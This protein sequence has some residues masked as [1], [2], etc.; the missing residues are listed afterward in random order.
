[1][2]RI[3][4]PK[5]SR[6]EKTPKVC[7][8]CG[9][10][11]CQTFIHSQ[12]GRKVKP[13]THQGRI[14]FAL[15]NEF[16]AII[17]DLNRANKIWGETI[18]GGVK[19]PPLA[20]IIYNAE[21][22]A[23]E[24]LEASRR[25]GD[26]LE[27]AD[28]IPNFTLPPDLSQQDHYRG[29]TVPLSRLGLR[30]PSPRDISNLPLPL[31]NEGIGKIDSLMRATKIGPFHYG[32]S[33]ATF[34][35]Q[36]M[37]IQP[38]ARHELKLTV[39]KTLQPLQ[40]RMVTYYDYYLGFIAIPNLDPEQEA[41]GAIRIAWAGVELMAALAC[42][43]P[44][45]LNI[46]PSSALK[47]YQE[48]T[49]FSDQTLSG[50]NFQKVMGMETELSFRKDAL[51]PHLQRY[52][53]LDKEIDSRAAEALSHQYRSQDRSWG[54]ENE[55][56]SGGALRR[57]ARYR[58]DLRSEVLKSPDKYLRLSVDPE[59]VIRDV[60]IA[61][62]NKQTL[63]LIVEIADGSHVTLEA[64]NNSRLFGIP[65]QLR[66]EFP[67][68]DDIIIKDVITP[69]LDWARPR[70]PRVEP[71]TKPATLTLSRLPD[72]E[73]YKESLRV[74]PEQVVIK[75]PKRRTLR[76]AIQ[77]VTREPGLPQPPEERRRIRRVIAASRTR[78][79]SLLPRNI[80]TEIIDKALS[81]I[82]DFEYGDRAAKSLQD[83]DVYS[84]RAG[85][86]RLILRRQEN[87]AYYLEAIGHRREVYRDYT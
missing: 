29:V 56:E 70:F 40:D 33:R 4:T 26:A 83:F 46:T 18:P 45:R 10:A 20:E 16:N 50:R 15:V 7:P 3:P 19:R 38:L 81:A 87:R 12:G 62:Q 78:V 31:D 37:P 82:H 67:H 86:Y 32:D 11:N 27:K 61:S 52:R 21:P 60:I 14:G 43:I 49:L 84:I 66:R 59:G 51:P 54:D 80:R 64:N 44:A 24:Y 2:E 69:I 30:G 76:S 58:A 75:P 53:H 73:T 72:A 28:T 63:M 65:P 71:S 68:I 22:F 8:H 39:P 5:L 34:L 74:T 55:D 48:K 36:I 6:V 13:T 47:L 17:G 42:Y 23:G 9:R 85:K 35:L 77:T 57:L 79:E 1:M 41:K 25:L